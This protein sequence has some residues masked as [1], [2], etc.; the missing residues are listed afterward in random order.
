MTSQKK[1]LHMQTI[2]RQDL[3][4]ICVSGVKH[5][6]IDK[7][8]RQAINPLVNFFITRGREQTEKKENSEWENVRNKSGITQ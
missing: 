1:G 4:E 8:E 3:F 6:R 5:G 2:Q 7:C